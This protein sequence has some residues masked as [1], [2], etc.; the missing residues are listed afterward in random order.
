MNKDL[1]LSPLPALFLLALAL[2]SCGISGPANRTPTLA[3]TQPPATQSATPVVPT[4]TEPPVTETV[5]PTAT[6][7]PVTETA[8]A[9]P[10]APST[11]TGYS[12]KVGADLEPQFLSQ[13]CQAL[14]QFGSRYG[15]LAISWNEIEP[16]KGRFNYARIEGWIDQFVACGQEMSVHVFSDAKW[17]TEP[18]PAGIPQAPRRPPAMPAKNPQDY[19]DFM[20]ALASHFSGKIA[21]YSIEVEAHAPQ[22]WGGTYEEYFQELQTAYKAIHAADP[23]A[24]VEDSG[25]SSTLLG[26]LA[27]YDM[28]QAG[29]TAGAVSYIRNYFSRRMPKGDL[30]SGSPDQLLQKAQQINENSALLRWIN[31]LMQ[32]HDYYDRLQVHY[33]APW[34]DLQTVTDYLHKKLAAIGAS[35]HFDYMEMAYGWDGA[36]GNGFD[37][38]AQAQDLTKLLTIAFGEGADRALQWEF[39]DYA[40]GI[41][42][43]GLIDRQ[44][45][46]RPA[47]T[48]FKVLSDKLTGATDG[49]R[50]SLGNNL[51]GY[52]FTRAGK[53]IFVVWSTSDMTVRL[54]FT[55]SATLTDIAGNVTPL[56]SNNVPV[57]PSPVYVEP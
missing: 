24:I 1:A 44:K 21:R 25:T 4:L 17:A 7:P 47:A 14:P 26:E 11:G 46:P 38:Q 13:A 3:P 56:D 30:V 16:S 50:L 36:P 40:I 20:Y 57:G 51:W 27:A 29:N 42:Q 31:L 12:I 28:Y 43:P 18:V 45:N 6:L 8:V 39:T 22:Y 2:S 52:E 48:S 33:Y 23:N 15:N 5:P 37:P 54:P 53:S 55:G 32:N 35:K 49:Q 34:Q 19:Y 41:G 10:I 9:T